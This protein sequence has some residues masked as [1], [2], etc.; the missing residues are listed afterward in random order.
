MKWEEQL[1]WMA[2]LLAILAANGMLGCGRPT[3]A[4]VKTTCAS[5]AAS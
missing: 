3:C 2:L 4:V 1:A 5:C